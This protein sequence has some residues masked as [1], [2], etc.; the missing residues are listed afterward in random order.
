MVGVCS[1]TSW[2]ACRNPN[3]TSPAPLSLPSL[4]N[5]SMQPLLE[6][7]KPD[8]SETHSSTAERCQTRGPLPWQRVMAS[9]WSGVRFPWLFRI[10][11]FFSFTFFLFNL[12]E[13]LIQYTRHVEQHN[14]DSKTNFRSDSRY[15]IYISK[16]NTCSFHNMVMHTTC[17]RLC[18]GRLQVGTKVC[19]Y[20]W[21]VDQV[22]E[23][24]PHFRFQTW[25]LSLMLLLIL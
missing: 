4:Q 12:V 14:V 23:F 9:S 7:R 21:K 25:I 13:Y 16:K 8:V 15:F 5:P 10:P 11:T 18:K 19:M 22:G 3:T 24:Y 1:S 2:N 20:N 17:K 6:T